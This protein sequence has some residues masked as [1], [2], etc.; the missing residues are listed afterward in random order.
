MIERRIVGTVN[1]RRD[2][3]SELN[4]HYFAELVQCPVHKFSFNRGN[5]LLY[6]A[7]E[8]DL[9]RTDPELVDVHA[10]I[11]SITVLLHIELKPVYS[12]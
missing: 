5:R 10:L 9:V 3:V 11:E 7:A 2:N 12:H 1:V 6:A 4:A 8:I